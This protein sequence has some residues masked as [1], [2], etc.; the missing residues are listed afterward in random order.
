MKKLHINEFVNK[1]FD[2]YIEQ[3]FSN[4]L[5][6]PLVANNFGKLKN[7]IKHNFG[8]IKAARDSFRVA[9]IE[10]KDRTKKPEAEISNDDPDNS[11]SVF[12]AVKHIVG[13]VTGSLMKRKSSN[14]FLKK[15]NTKK[16][17][18]NSSPNSTANSPESSPEKSITNDDTEHIN[19]STDTE[20][21][22]EM[23]K[24]VE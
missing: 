18:V 1:F 13:G 22:V 9:K 4:Y 15:S 12:G 19:N 24:K 14:K 16:R 6:M 3:F 23:V 21:V 10:F 7:N 2:S 20:M 8:K 5:G 17:D 11:N